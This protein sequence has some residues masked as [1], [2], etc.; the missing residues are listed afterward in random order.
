MRSS[1]VAKAVALLGLLALPA[2]PARGQVWR[3]D[4]PPACQER[5]PEVLAVGGGAFAAVWQ[6]GAEPA[7][8]GEPRIFV[9]L[10]DPHGVP[11]GPEFQVSGDYDAVLLD[12]AVNAE[13]RFLVLWHDLLRGQLRSRAFSAT[14]QPL[15]AEK[16]VFF[17]FVPPG[18][19]LTATND[20]GFA[21]VTAAGLSVDLW[22]FDSLGQLHAG[23]PTEVESWA[24]V[25]PEPPTF[26]G[27]FE[28]RIEW[29]DHAGN[30]GEG[31]AISL[32]N[33][34]GYF[35]FFGPE[36][37]EV[38]VKVLDGRAVNGRFWIFYEALTDVEYTLLV[39]DTETDEVKTYHNPAGQLRSH[40]DTAA[41]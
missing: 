16:V 38:M 33:D 22:R 27:R 11:R 17:D 10:F 9:R 20:G 21:L 26:D 8:V 25:A 19:A 14:G 7:A 41:F 4:T 35:W 29:T 32:S 23:P 36:N 5:A 37:V 34:S 1:L 15:G 18:V 2:L 3:L 31:R 12:A 6:G 39:R 30:T 40:A 13:G 28:A 24:S